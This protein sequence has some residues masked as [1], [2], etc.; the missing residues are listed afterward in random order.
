MAFTDSGRVIGEEAVGQA[1]TNPKHTVE[2]LHLLLGVPHAEV[3]SSGWAKHC[4]YAT[5]S[6]EGGATEVSTVR[7]SASDSHRGT[8]G[9]GSGG[10]EG[11]A[12]GGSGGSTM[13][14]TPA[15]ASSPMT[16]ASTA[17]S[18][19]QMIGSGPG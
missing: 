13:A 15:P 5:A 10:A 16:A 8:T 1:S 17:A 14:A 3:A 7:N 19:S 11:D 6:G 18:G 12:V 9:S 4:S 2:N